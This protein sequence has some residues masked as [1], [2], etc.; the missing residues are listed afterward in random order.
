MLSPFR[1]VG[2]V[3]PVTSAQVAES[4]FGLGFEKLDR[5][6][7]NPEPAYDLVGATG[8]KWIRIQSGWAR[9]EKERGVYDFGWLDS[10]V[11]NL[12]ARG[13]R[14]WISCGF[15][16]PLYD[17]EAA[18]WF[19]AVGCPPIHTPEQRQ[20][21]CNYI[22]ALARHFAGRVEWYEIW[23][24]PDG[25]G[26]WKC[27]V[28]PAEYADLIMMTAPALRKGCPDVKIMGGG[29]RARESDLLTYADR[30]F[31]TDA[32]KMIDALSY[33][34]YD[35]AEEDISCKMRALRAL[36]RSYNPAVEIIQGEAGAQSRQDGCGALRQ[37]QW[38]EERQARFLARHMM[39]HLLDGVK[40]T[41]YFT[42]VDMVEAIR[43]RVG[44]LA[45]RMDF[46]YFGVLAADFDDEGIATGNYTPKQSYRALQTL[47]AIFHGK[48][49]LTELPIYFL[50]TEIT[51][52]LRR[53]DDTSAGLFHGGFRR[54]N[55]SAAFVY[56]KPADLL[57]ET[58]HGA[59][60]L[61]FARLPLPVRLIRLK[62][63]EILEI[64]K[65]CD[66]EAA[67]GVRRLLHLPLLD[68]PMLVTFGDFIPAVK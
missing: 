31:R 23:N 25:K 60:S 21:W 68:E 6:V 12:I 49:T 54:D 42:S 7:F 37:M 15:G 51:P 18:K 53:L 28:N 19:G 34:G 13:L 29:L 2:K 41:S 5:A 43:G 64:P 40:F 58:Y 33:H 56:W 45:S 32:V 36:I 27:G 11:D 65:E 67:P 57:T 14:P 4:P 24:E 48:W 22:T 50:R 20:A 39:K 46:G 52:L 44:D 35:I 1:T 61:E 66:I 10:I 62:T 38:T 16:N 8:V 47:A 17:E 63:G 9:T 26:F 59:V 30:V 3:A 55:G